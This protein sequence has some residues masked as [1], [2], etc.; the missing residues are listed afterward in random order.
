V[1]TRLSGEL[2]HRQELVVAV[3]S[4]GAGSY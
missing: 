4:D 2:A 1:G 3:L